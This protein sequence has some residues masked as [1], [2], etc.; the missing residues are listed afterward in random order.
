MR[1]RYAVIACAV[2]VASCSGSQRS[3]ERRGTSTT[4]RHAV[5]ACDDPGAAP[6]VRH[7]SSRVGS[8]W[9]WIESVTRP[10]AR[11]GSLVKVV[12]RMTG[13]GAP[14]AELSGP[15]GRR[16][17]LSF[18]PEPHSASTFDHPGAEYGTGFTPTAP[19]CWRLT[20]RRGEV[21][22]SVSFAVVD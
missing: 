4:A 5:I 11:V 13:T 20:M 14:R 8:V 10:L 22:S 1:R 9:V 6:S 2:L 3:A 7:L 17:Q 15:G 12:W 21:E 16:A 18:G 19:G